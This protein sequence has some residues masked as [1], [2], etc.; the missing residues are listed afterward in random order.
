MV[1]SATMIYFITGAPAAGKSTLVE[2]LKQKCKYESWAFLHFDSIGV[3]PVSEITSMFSSTVQRQQA[4]TFQW[5]DRLVQMHEEKV[6]FEGQVNPNFII[7]GF[8]R[9]NFN[10]YQIILLD[11]DEEEMRR[12]LETERNQPE[13]FTPAMKNWRFV[14]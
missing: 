6:I 5:I 2:L 12:R 11:C 10:N 13:L 8:A 7:E 14:T 3:P 4:M 9:H 1:V